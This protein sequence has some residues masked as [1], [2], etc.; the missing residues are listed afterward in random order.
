MRRTGTALLHTEELEATAEAAVLFAA[1]FADAAMALLRA[2]TELPGELADGAA[3]RMLLEMYHISGKRSE[4]DALAA[5]YRR[6][7]GLATAPAWG[8]PAP[9]NATGMFVLKGVIASNRDLAE[10]LEHGR[11]C[12]T[13]AIDMSEVQRID[14]GF[15]ISFSEVLRFFHDQRK[16]VILANVGEIHAALLETLGTNQHLVLLRRNAARTIN[17]AVIAEHDEP[18]VPLIPIAGIPASALQGATA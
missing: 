17:A 1:N 6:A 2:H 12:M 9:V 18:R 8:Y 13:V 7:F 4:F 3:W 14:F 15:V 11:T 16:R 5:R 10:L